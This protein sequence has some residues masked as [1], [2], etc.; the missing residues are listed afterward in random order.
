[1]RHYAD[2]AGR[3]DVLFGRGN[4]CHLLPIPWR[5]VEGFCRICG[6]EYVVRNSSPDVL[7]GIPSGGVVRLVVSSDLLLTGR[8]RSSLIPC[9]W[10]PGS[11]IR[12]RPTSIRTEKAPTSLSRGTL[13]S[14]LKRFKHR[15]VPFRATN[16][17]SMPWRGLLTRYLITAFRL[18]KTIPELLGIPPTFI[19]KLVRA[20]DRNGCTRTDKIAELFTVVFPRRLER[21]SWGELAYNLPWRSKGQWRPEVAPSTRLQDA[22]A[23]LHIDSGVTY[24]DMAAMKRL[25]DANLGVERLW[26]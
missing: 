7:V 20:K 14:T 2:F 26:K 15:L 17:F 6:R 23:M 24:E 18:E 4:P 13:S 3:P 10:R 25:L 1:M 16:P 11:S 19:E 5:G 21:G 12:C 8:L 22:H 9:L